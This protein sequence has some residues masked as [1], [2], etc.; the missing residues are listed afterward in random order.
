[1]SEAGFWFAGAGLLA[2]GAA[3]AWL[4]R[5]AWQ[6]KIEARA[7]WLWGG[8][9]VL[10]A[11]LFWPAWVLGPARGPFIAATLIPV[12]ALALIATGLQL[13]AARAGRAAGSESLAPEPSERPSK[14]W[15]GVLRWLLAGPVGMIAALAVGIAYAAFTPGDPQTRLVLGGMIVPVA[16]GGAMAWTL[17]DNRILRATGVLLGT[18]LLGFGAAWLRGFA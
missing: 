6:A 3:A 15:R 4:L 12:A 1:M 5:R 17:A 16:W 7:P 18:A 9:A 10:A 14:A 13:R 2:G 8:W 11:T